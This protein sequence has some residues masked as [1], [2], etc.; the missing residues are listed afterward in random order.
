MQSFKSRVFYHIVRYTISKG[1]KRQ[2]SLPAM[3]AAEGRRAM[4]MPSGV[5][6][7]EACVGGLQGEWHR[8]AKAETD[9]ILLYLH[10][11]AYALGSFRTHRSLGA[12]LARASGFST[13]VS[14]YRLAPEDPF[15]AAV[16]DA[17]SVYM[18]LKEEFPKA[19]IAI[20]GD[21]AGGGLVLAL[22]L[23]LQE[24]GLPTPVAMALLSPWT[25]LSLSNATHKTKAKVDPFFPSTSVLHG[26]AQAYAGGN[27]LT[28]PLIS[29]Q[30]ASLHGL[31]PT[32]IH[33]GELE[34]LLDDSRLIAHRL[35]AAGVNVTIRVFPR[36]WHVWQAFAGHFR[37]A[38]E[39]INEIGEFLKRYRKN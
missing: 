24:R 18:A 36:M 20:A 35:Q 32:L 16:D 33:V 31:P 38:D 6:S 13:F 11:G 2:L 26:A 9:A 14:N 19:A 1:Q 30:Y 37:E 27:S 34:A 25:D 21:S 23:S 3:R 4:K 29:P 8:P 17:V 7:E 15:P 28:H 12:N 5:L 10:G 22:A 39:S